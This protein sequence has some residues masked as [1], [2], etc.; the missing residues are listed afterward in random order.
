M[1]EEEEEGNEW[2]FE[3]VAGAAFPASS[4]HAGKLFGEKQEKERI[5]DFSYG[6]PFYLRDS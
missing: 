1:E 2:K 5:W 3:P 6:F 4:S